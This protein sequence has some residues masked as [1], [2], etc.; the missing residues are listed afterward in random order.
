MIGGLDDV[1]DVERRVYRRKSASLEYIPR[2]IMSQ[3]ATLDI[4]GIVG[5]LYP[6][7]V[8]NATAK[9][10]VLLIFQNIQ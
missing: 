1:V 7:L 8:I 10:R 4:I 2:L 6:S 5:E 3:S 9:T